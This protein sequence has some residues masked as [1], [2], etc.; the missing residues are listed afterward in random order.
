M[1]NSPLRSFSKFFFKWE[2]ES[3]SARA[4]TSFTFCF[5]EVSHGFASQVLRGAATFAWQS[6]SSRE[7][8]PYNHIKRLNFTIHGM[9]AKSLAANDIPKSVFILSRFSEDFVLLIDKKTTHKNPF[10]CLYS[11]PKNLGL[12]KAW[13]AFFASSRKLHSEALILLASTLWRSGTVCVLKSRSS[14]RAWFK[15][16]GNF[17]GISFHFRFPLRNFQDTVTTSSKF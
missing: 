16:Q 2:Q 13:R 10:F 3:V 9:E 7:I 6:H 12:S 14:E 11:V 5:F 1:S 17:H 4:Q 15:S 8:S